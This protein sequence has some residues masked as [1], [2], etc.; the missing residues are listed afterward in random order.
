MNDRP[1][2]FDPIRQRA[3]QRWDQLEQ[4]PEL[5]GPW[6][7][8]FNQ[9]QSPRHILSELLQ[10]ADDAGA[11]EAS[12]R[13]EDRSFIFTHNGEDFTEEHFASLCRFAYSN[14]RDLHTIGFRGIGFKS[15]FSLGDT[16]ELYTPTLS[17]AFNRQRFTE[18]R[19]VDS[20][21]SDADSTQVRVAISDEHRQREVEK[22]LQEWLKS[23]VSLLFF[24]HI[25]HLR[26]GE[27][28]V[29][30]G[31]LGPGPVPQTERMA[32][33]ADPDQVFLVA[34]SGAEPFP[35]ESLDE[36]MQERLLGPDQ[37]TEF[38]PCKVEIVLGAKGRLYVVLPTGVE[39]S[40]PFACNAPF[41]QDP[42]R[43]KIK[44]PETS[45]TNRWL[46]ERIGLL[47]ASVMLQWLECT[48]VSLAERS[49]AYGLFPDV[50]R[51]DNSLEGLCAA[52]VEEAFD[53]SIES[54]AFLLTGVG[55]LRPAG[56]S[57][58][59]PEPLFDVWPAEQASVL[60]DDAGRPAFSYYVSENDTE[61]LIHRN[62]VEKIDKD[63]ILNVLQTKHLPRLKNWRCL[64]KLWAYA[65]TEMTGYRP[66]VCNN[67]QVRI[68]PVQGKDVLY[69]ASEVVRIGERRLLQAD[70]DWDFLAAHL[71]V[72]NQNWS[73]FLA[74]R[75]RDT[76]ESNDK[77]LQSDVDA[78]YAV[79]KAIGLEETSDISTM[80][81]QVAL[82][83]FRKESIALSDCIQISQIAG[84]LGATVG[85]SFR[86][87]TRDRHLRGTKHVVLFDADGTLEALFP[88]SW[89]SE[90]LLHPDYTKSFDSCTSEEWSG[91]ISSGRAGIQTF[92]PLVQTGSTIWGEK[93]INVELYKRGFVGEA[94]YPYTSKQFRIGDWDFEE[95][96]WAHW[97]LI[98]DDDNLWGHLVDRIIN[99]PERYWLKATSARIFQVASNGYTRS[100]TSDPLLPAWII[101][102]RDL[103]CLPDTRGFYNRPAD[104]LRRTPE[105]ESL[106]DV[107]PFI[108][109]RIDTESTR[110]LLKLLGVRDTPTGPD[111]LL[112]CLRALAKADNP[113]IYE[114]E[115]WY[116]RLDRMIETC[117]TADF[118]KIKKALYEENVILIEGSGWAKASGVFLSSDQEN[119]PGAAVVRASVSDLSLWRKIAIAERPTAD[120]AI[121]WLKELTSGKTLSQDDTR[122]VRALLPRHAA[123][124]WKE[125][126]HWLNLA[127]EWAP[128][129][130]I[131]FALTMQTLVPWSHLHEWV[132][133]KTAD[134]QRLPIEITEAWPFCDVPTLSS[135]IEDRFH[136]SPL[137]PD[138]PERKPWLNMIGVE[139]RRIDLDDV[140]ETARI[141]CLAAELAETRWQTTQGLEIVPYID[142]TP[143]GTSRHA[144]VVWLNKMLYV[145]HL[146][147]AKLARLVP[148]RLG[149]IFG[150][151]DITAALNYCFGRSSEEVT[152]YLEEN[153][154]LVPCDLVVPL[155]VEAA[156]STCEHAITD[157]GAAPQTLSDETLTDHEKAA[158]GDEVDAALVAQSEGKEEPT[159]DT[160]EH[161]G[162]LDGIDV[163]P[164]KVYPHPKPTKPRIIERFAQGMGFR[165]DGDDRFFHADGRWIAKTTGDRFPW[166][167][168]TAAGEIVR[169]FWPKD[170][171]LEQEPLQLEADIWGLIDSFPEIYALV[172]SNPQG[173]PVEVQG[174][175]LRAMRAGGKITLYPA[176]YRLVYNDDN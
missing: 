89:C 10:N 62:V 36:I 119:V 107:E 35:R 94:N 159:K 120:L 69:A 77:S 5:A 2:F 125:C 130:T 40:L 142:G 90:H 75:R 115:K 30:W 55:E 97:T 22:N 102:F 144:E 121:Q 60:L 157:T 24:R 140:A 113:P 122:R 25:R 73:R 116:R 106:M 81:E 172:L 118:E 163:T 33:Q 32:L 6:H 108:H 66:L 132:K 154:K 43:L 110:P 166:E 27:Q 85:E 72:F 158:T 127:G 93:A 12:V 61:K 129:A 114:V 21:N 9:V 86:F 79:L 50:D 156:A 161:S 46:L 88:E 92:A 68:V 139:L 41:I 47:A 143:A 150:R 34:R 28:E 42:A 58:V 176:T 14:K 44:D 74:E 26:I 167:M 126:G 175:L 7:Q 4:D 174:A 78:A 109:G 13:I 76:E 52:T 151:S 131:S 162:E 149:K 100:I 51:D 148:D 146:P 19:W 23:P 3:S 70:A 165:K 155:S 54:K 83:F 147:N 123:R 59:I 63:H 164:Q 45:P 38:P 173:E 67:R 111:R 101:K 98:E 53:T 18:P 8:L 153:F 152:E 99:Q 168:R 11:T 117:S 17:V 16:V 15:T 169:Y 87:A 124:I 91:W 105:T 56:Q 31:S 57:V 171:C 137:S 145:D 20:P 141:R 80:V 95:S 135:R 39:T 104:L 138:R 82:D 128:T 84:K 112:D 65:A 37:G 29:Y 71:L 1:A 48:S 136:R 103:P 160:E 64:L 134:F 49:C 170:H 133:Q 96:N